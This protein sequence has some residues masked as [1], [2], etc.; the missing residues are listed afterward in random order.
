MFGIFQYLITHLAPLFLITSPI[1]SYA[2]QIYSIHR[3]RSSTGFSLDIPLIMLLTSILKIFWWFNAPY[4][5]TLFIQALIM[6]N[7]QLLLLHVALTHRAPPA[8]KLA[9]PFEDL[10][11]RRPY[12]FWQWRSTRPYWSFL[13][14]YTAAL[15]VLQVL[16]ARNALYTSLQGYVALS[17]EALLPLPQIVANQRGRSCKGFRLSVLAN[18]LVGDAMK[19]SFFFLA[20]SEIPWAFKLCAVFQA[21]CDCYLGVQ[22]WMFGEGE[23]EGVEMGRIRGDKGSM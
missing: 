21:C 14:Y 11:H 7:V 16:F 10:S 20:E 6:I 5:T 23:R 17:I 22:Y 8:A 2:D 3:T 12:D 18:W 19:M 13:G 9:T 1:T 4:D 15:L